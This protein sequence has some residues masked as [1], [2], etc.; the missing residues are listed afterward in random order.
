MA[1]HAPYTSQRASRQDSSS[2]SFEDD[3]KVS[4][5]WI[6]DR[7][8]ASSAA[9]ANR[10]RRA[11]DLAKLDTNTN[12]NANA[13][14]AIR[15]R[16][17][18][19]AKKVEK[20]QRIGL[21]RGSSYLDPKKS[22]D[23]EEL[24][25]VIGIQ[26]DALYRAYLP[27]PVAALRSLIVAVLRREAP[28]M[29]R[30][31]AWIRR[32]WLDRYFVNTSLLGT[33]SFFL[34][35]LPMAYWLGNAK[36][37]RGL[38]NV[39]ALGVY[40]SS[41]LKDLFCIPRPYSPPVTRLTIGTHHLEYGFP[42]THSTNSVS[43]A[44]Y[45]YLWVT[46]F[47]Q[48]PL[49]AIQHG[50]GGIFDSLWWEAGLLFYAF[51][52]VYGR[53][54]A[55]MHS[56]IDC[57]VGSSLGA[58]ISWMQWRYFDQM[59]HFLQLDSWV[60][61]LVIVPL[62][63]LMVSV[64][65]QPMEDCPCFEDAIAFVAV[66]MGTT[67]G[68]WFG[69]KFGLHLAHD[70]PLK[71]LGPAQRALLNAERLMPSSSTV[72]KVVVPV[73]EAV[74]QPVEA[75][76]LGPDGTEVDGAGVRT[77]K[78]TLII[79]VGVF[80]ILLLRVVVKTACM[81]VLPP[82]FRF[83]SE[84]VGFSLPRRHYTPASDYNKI[85]LADLTAVPSVIDLPSTII[86][87]DENGASSNLGRSGEAAN[88][89]AS[90]A[91]GRPGAAGEDG[92]LRSRLS[93]QP[94]PGRIS[95]QG[96]PTSSLFNPSPLASPIPSRTPSP[97]M[98]KK[99]AG[100]QAVAAAKPRQQPPGKRI[101]FSIGDGDDGSAADL[102]IPLT[103]SRAHPGFVAPDEK[104]ARQLAS[105]IEGAPVAKVQQDVKHYDAEVLTKVIVYSGIGF[106]ASSLIPALFERIGLSS[107]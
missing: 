8:A 39:L 98:G 89:M 61:P 47:R 3:T 42:S 40:L 88:G 12:A 55:G 58:W 11:D 51:S 13:P 90:G 18:E 25:T 81:V 99:S 32:P 2:S 85:P 37:A 69:I 73:L 30:H 106:A 41:A 76:S 57:V 72:A 70:N 93:V 31:Q 10:Q 7:T 91:T 79:V 94:S 100:T 36:F 24:T 17:K 68:K 66:A 54:Y 49:V 23:R 53:I 77:V 44:L 16:V 71:P 104:A 78:A 46:A 84:S 65:P 87:T 48:L 80:L 1:P 86:V 67:L 101:Q 96:S 62:G 102:P 27:R 56:L 105:A 92:Q 5:S 83:F 22:T 50:L 64:H 19:G 95:G 15:A 52:V 107:V 21:L 38:V 9:T 29:A 28:H 74:R 4:G 35:F 20:I 45:L 60:V 63:L 33:H 6:E 103:Q 26:D 14:Q 34:I 43:I 97:A 59:E 75:L 82:V